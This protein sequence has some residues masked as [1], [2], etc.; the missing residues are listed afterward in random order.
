MA[1]LLLRV[2]GPMQSWGTA[3]RF[4]RRDS[5][6]EPSKSGILGL[7]CAALGRDRTEPIDDL[8]ALRMGVRVDRAG[9]LKYDYQTARGVRK[10][11]NSGLFP[12]VPSWRYYLA[13]AAFLVGLESPVDTDLLG[14]VEKALLNPRWPLFLGRKGY[15]PSPPVWLPNGL[16]DK[17][18][19]EALAGFPP[20]T[21]DDPDQY[22]Y[23]IEATATSRFQARGTVVRRQDQPVGSFAERRFADRYVH[24]VVAQKGEVPLVSL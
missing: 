23:A 13:D 7:I 14:Q 4:D 1:T 8:A 16:V 22:R 17:P 19:E 10:A 24:L 20:L 9:V 21:D 2:Q 3:S 18:L 12:T 5:A 6:L 15:L 11:D